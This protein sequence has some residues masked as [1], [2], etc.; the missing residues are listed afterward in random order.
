M[1]LFDLRVAAGGGSGGLVGGGPTPGVQHQAVAT[2]S[3]GGEVLSLDWNKYRPMTIATGSTDRGV[4]VWDLRRAGVPTM[5]SSP[6]EMP[7]TFGQDG[8]MVAALLGH[9]YAV[10][11]VAWSP[12]AASI[13]C[14]ASYD[15]TARIWDV[16]AAQQSALGGGAMGARFGQQGAGG[17]K[18][19]HDAHTE[20]VVGA[21]WALFQEGLIA[22]CAWDCETHLW[23][24][25]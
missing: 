15:M 10:R 3:V 23:R 13:L 1:R 14:S 2:V 12:H 22:T 9:E 7:K 21:A 17:L 16:D 11:K 5:T 25:L 20:F 18:M 24:G 19:V 6:G 4:K 8:T